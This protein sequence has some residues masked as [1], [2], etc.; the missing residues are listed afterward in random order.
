MDARVAAVRSR[1]VFKKLENPIG[2]AIGRLA[3]RFLVE[4]AVMGDAGVVS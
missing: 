2:I 1:V 3:A 4:E